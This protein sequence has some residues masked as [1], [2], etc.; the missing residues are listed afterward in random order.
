MDKRNKQGV[1][2]KKNHMIKKKEKKER[3]C[4]HC[5]W[6]VYE[7]ET[8]GDF[9]HK[10]AVEQ[11]KGFCVIKDLFNYTDSDYSCNAFRRE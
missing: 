9:D 2:E 6:W 1:Q 8:V 5:E 11:G 4:Q 3:K 7:G 10:Y